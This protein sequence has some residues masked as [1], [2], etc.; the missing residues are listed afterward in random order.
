MCQNLTPGI[1]ACLGLIEDSLQM[2]VGRGLPHMWGV[3]VGRLEDADKHV[4][5]PAEEIKQDS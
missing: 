2:N 1:S 4:K 5:N 3:R